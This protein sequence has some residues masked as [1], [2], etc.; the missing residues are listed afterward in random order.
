LRYRPTSTRMNLFWSITSKIKEKEV[1]M[2]G[3]LSSMHPPIDFTCLEPAG[4]WTS[5]WLEFFEGEQGQPVWAITLAFAKDDVNFYIKTMPQDRYDDL[6]SANV[7]DKR[8]AVAEDAVLSLINY[9]LAAGAAGP[10][11]VIGARQRLTGYIPRLTEE[12]AHDYTDW[13]QIA[14]VV[15]DRQSAFWVREFGGWWVAFSDS[16]GDRYVICHGNGIPMQEFKLSTV[17]DMD[18][19]TN[20]LDQ[21]FSLELLKSSDQRRTRKVKLP[22]NPEYERLMATI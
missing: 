2:E 18:R 3:N 4:D 20:G 15:D 6:M 19:L 9:S 22:L 17:D 5:R 12:L 1:T 14:A 13:E 16:V 7:D 21:P 11:P 8:L 10:G